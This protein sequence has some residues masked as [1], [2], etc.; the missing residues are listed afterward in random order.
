[1]SF[2]RGKKR[3]VELTVLMKATISCALRLQFIQA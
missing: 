2:H 3:R 1:M